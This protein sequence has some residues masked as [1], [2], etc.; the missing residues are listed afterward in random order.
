[1]SR[2]PGHGPAGPGGV[3][4]LRAALLAVVGVVI[5]VLLLQAGQHAALSGGAA[6]GS[7]AGRGTGTSTTTTTTVPATTTTVATVHPSTSVKVL[8]ANASNTN[9]VATYYTG[10]LS[11]AGW[12]TLSP[13]NASA[14]LTTSAVYYATGQQGAADAVAS[15]LGVAAAQVQPLGSQTPVPG[16][17][18][19]DVVVAVGNDLAAK[20]SPGG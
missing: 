7:P 1:M 15:A 14:R 20:A 8:V 17:T 5:G 2:P 9:G 18:G 10:T 11:S 13:T 6:S 12:G 19:A 16:T 3:R 4:P